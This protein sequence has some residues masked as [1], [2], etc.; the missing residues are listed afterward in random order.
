MKGSLPYLQ[1]LAKSKPKVRK[2]LIQNVP[3]SVITAIYECCLNTFKGV[4]PLTQRQSAV[5]TVQDTSPC[6]GEQESFSKT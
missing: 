4:I 2:I 1:I 6:I 3:D 5:G